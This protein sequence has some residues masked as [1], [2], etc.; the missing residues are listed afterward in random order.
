MAI[1]RITG[2]K[3]QE[4]RK[5]EQVERKNVEARK[6]GSSRPADTKPATTEVSDR[7]KA[8]VKAYRLAAESKPDISRVQRV[9]ELKAEIVRGSYDV[10]SKNVADSIISSVVKGV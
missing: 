10:S 9:A 8:A 1:E 3:P 7:S 4:I 2:G 5:S 6:E